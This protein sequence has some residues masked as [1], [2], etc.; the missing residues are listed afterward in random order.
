[1]GAAPV[2]RILVGV[3]GRSLSVM[4]GMVAGARD[5]LDERFRDTE[6]GWQPLAL[7]VSGGAIGAVAAA[8]GMR[9]EQLRKLAVEHPESMVMGKRNIG[10]M[11]R[12]R[13]LYP[14]ARVHDLAC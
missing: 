5:A 4:V 12:N 7:G 1:M 2:V 8:T 13:V 9:R 3:A 6:T 14:H 11:L 10:S